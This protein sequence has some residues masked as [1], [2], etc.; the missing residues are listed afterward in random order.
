MTWHTKQRCTSAQE[1]T[2]KQLAYYKSFYSTENARKV[3][4]DIRRYIYDLVV[5]TSEVAVAKCM[6]ID[7]YE[8]IRKSSGVTDELLVIERESTVP[9]KDNK[10]KEEKPLDLQ[11]IT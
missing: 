3:N 9:F 2:E 8:Y 11:E 6:L 10:P 4:A 5:E 1:E 7:L